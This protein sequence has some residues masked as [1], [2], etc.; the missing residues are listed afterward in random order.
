MQII[1]GDTNLPKEMFVCDNDIVPK[2]IKRFVCIDK[3]DWMWLSENPNAISVLEQNPEKINWTWLSKNPN[4]IHLLGN[5]K[6]RI[7]WTSC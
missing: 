4:A 6:H 7:N 5:N 2:K 1:F 3:I